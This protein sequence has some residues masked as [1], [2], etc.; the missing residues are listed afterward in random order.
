MVVTSEATDTG[1]ADYGW[2]AAMI[3]N[4]WEAVWGLYSGPGFSGVL[5]PALPDTAAIIVDVLEEALPSP[6]WSFW[7][8]LTTDAPVEGEE[9]SVWSSTA[10]IQTDELEGVVVLQFLSGVVDDGVFFDEPAF[11][12]TLT[13]LPLTLSHETWGGI[14]SVLGTGR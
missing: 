8:V 11:P 2:V 6:P 12:C 9:G 3:P 10:L 13:V 14:K 5:S 7:A 4:G 1:D